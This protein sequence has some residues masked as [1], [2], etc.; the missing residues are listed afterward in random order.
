MP[1]GLQQ[2]VV[3]VPWSFGL[4][5]FGGGNVWRCSVLFGGADQRGQQGH[6]FPGIG[7]QGGLQVVA[8]VV[9]GPVL[10]PSEVETDHSRAGVSGHARRAGKLAGI[11]EAGFIDQFG[12][13][14]GEEHPV[15]ILFR[16]ARL[17]RDDRQRGDRRARPVRCFQPCLVDPVP[18]RRQLAQHH[19]GRFSVRH[20]DGLSR[21]ENHR[22]VLIA[23]HADEGDLADAVP[24]HGREERCF[25][26]RRNH[27]QIPTKGDL[28]KVRGS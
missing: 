3:I 17:G 18:C 27:S 14:Y 28:Y 5:P 10:L 7:G 19:G 15:R 8:R 21:L 16:P 6:A 13:V 22:P 11:L 23:H 20:L 24:P 1:F 4:D 2:V 9:S 26:A 25:R 12:L